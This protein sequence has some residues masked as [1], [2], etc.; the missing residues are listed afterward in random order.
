M[1]QYTS[2]SAPLRCPFPTCVKSIAP[3]SVTLFSLK[4]CFPHSIPITGSLGHHFLQCMTFHIH[5][6]YSSL[7]GSTFVTPVQCTASPPAGI[8][9]HWRTGLPLPAVL[10]P[11]SLWWFKDLGQSELFL[12][13]LYA[14]PV[15][16]LSSTRK[17]SELVK[18]EFFQFCKF[19]WLLDLWEFRM[20]WA[21]LGMWFSR[22]FHISG[23]PHEPFI[24][25]DFIL[26]HISTSIC[27]LSFYFSFMSF[28][29]P[30]NCK[31]F[32]CLFFSLP[33]SFILLKKITYLKWT[34]QKVCHTTKS[35]PH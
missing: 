30:K 4:G 33:K 32:S 25:L 12:C 1:L 3:C 9:A 7:S 35:C 14:A 28:T 2:A 20:Y 29:S 5:C 27:F 22:C 24:S 19:F 16:L 23:Y 34:I 17:I 6:C 10:L 21:G 31:I 18:H 15:I 11:P 13:L 26:F 8:T